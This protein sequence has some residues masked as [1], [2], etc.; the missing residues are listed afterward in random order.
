MPTLQLPAWAQLSPDPAATMGKSPVD[1]RSCGRGS[2]HGRLVRLLNG[3]GVWRAMVSSFLPRDGGRSQAGCPV[4]GLADL[5]VTGVFRGGA[6]PPGTHRGWV[7]CWGMW[8]RGRH[9]P[10]AAPALGLPFWGRGAAKAAPPDH[11]QS[12]LSAAPTAAAMALLGTQRALFS[13]VGGGH[14]LSPPVAVAARRPRVVPPGALV[15]RLPVPEDMFPGGEGVA[16]SCLTAA[17]AEESRRSC[18]RC[19][20]EGNNRG[21][22]KDE[23]PGRGGRKLALS[24]EKCCSAFNGKANQTTAGAEAACGG[25]RGSGLPASA[26]DAYQ[27]GTWGWVCHLGIWGRQQR[28][29]T[30]NKLLG[31]VWG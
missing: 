28:P 23:T 24:R 17:L 29:G 26:G 5:V 11:R 16:V 15:L 30:V 2:E 18:D 31:L 7:T 13:L 6:I 3:S 10:T 12:C 20:D 19:R 27:D 22:G 25:D 14:L 1:T 8:R 4:P 21:S 9:V